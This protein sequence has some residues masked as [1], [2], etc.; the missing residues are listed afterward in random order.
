MLTSPPYGKPRKARLH[1]PHIP[2]HPITSP[3]H[4]PITPSPHHLI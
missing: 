4:L 2:H 1:T 3:P